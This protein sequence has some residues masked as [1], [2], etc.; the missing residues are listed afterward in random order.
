MGDVC[1]S[2]CTGVAVH[3]SESRP[4]RADGVGLEG[5]ATVAVRGSLGYDDL[6]PELGYDLIVSNVPGKAGPAVIDELVTG[7]AAVAGPGA[8]VGFVVVNPLVEAVRRLVVEPR[9]EPL[10]DKGNKTHSVVLGRVVTT[11]EVSEAGAFDRGIYDRHTGTFTSKDL[12]WRARTVV[13]LD[14]F[15]S[16]A[17]P[18]RLLRHALQGVRSAPSMVIN[19]GQ[20]HRAVIAALAGYPPAVLVSRDLLALRASAR[21]LADAGFPEPDRLVHSITSDDGNDRPPVTILH[22]DDKVHGP[23]LTAE[24]RRYLD[25]VAAFDWHAGAEQPQL[26]LSGRSG[27]LGRLE[28]DVLARRPGHVAYKKSVKGHR[29]LRFASKL[30]KR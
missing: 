6:G 27:I 7:A 2:R 25:A 3:G 12:T 17:Q 23:W 10:L 15:D 29:V 28:A 14:E 18:T 1:G 5:E 4:Q 13:G 30:P 9:F 22:A 20:G 8:I 11:D 21:C 26:V 19:P 24:V 16:L